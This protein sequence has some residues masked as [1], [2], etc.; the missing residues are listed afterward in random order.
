MS[1]TKYR[2]STR[3]GPLV[4]TT[5]TIPR[6]LLHDIDALVNTRKLADL[7]FNRSALIELAL[8]LHLDA[9]HPRR[10]T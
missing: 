7:S 1:R 4:K 8:R 2:G 5:I 10:P 9:I 3:E 6:D